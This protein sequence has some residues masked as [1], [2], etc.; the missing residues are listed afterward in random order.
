MTYR[1]KSVKTSLR[2]MEAINRK[3][4]KGERIMPKTDEKTPEQVPL[5]GKA[6]EIVNALELARTD[7]NIDINRCIEVI[8]KK[9]DEMKTLTKRRE[10]LD[11]ALI[12][13]K[14]MAEEQSSKSPEEEI[15][16]DFIKGD[17]L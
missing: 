8:T 3:L 4:A 11:S 13:A 9:S 17:S 7:V 5:F 2:K 6:D 10:Q 14:K 15:I 12:T 16:E 1:G